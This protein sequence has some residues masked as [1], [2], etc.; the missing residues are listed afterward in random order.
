MRKEAPPLIGEGLSSEGSQMANSYRNC[1]ECRKRI[2]RCKYIVTAEPVPVSHGAVI[3]VSV[4]AT[5]LG[6]KYRVVL[7]KLDA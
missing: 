3:V 4:D 2:D 5:Y 1:P 6:K 7:E